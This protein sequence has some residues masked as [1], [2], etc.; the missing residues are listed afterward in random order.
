MSSLANA[1]EREA[2]ELRVWRTLALTP[3]NGTL[4]FTACRAIRRAFDEVI[5]HE[6]W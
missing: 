2:V 6:A 1:E 5:H 3:G 4:I